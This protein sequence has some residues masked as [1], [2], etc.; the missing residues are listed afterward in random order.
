LPAKS[1]A[2]KQGHQ[3]KLDIFPQNPD[4]GPSRIKDLGEEKRKTP[5]QDTSVMPRHITD[6]ESADENPKNKNKHA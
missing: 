3:L 6:Q 4:S 2:R 1:P 5:S